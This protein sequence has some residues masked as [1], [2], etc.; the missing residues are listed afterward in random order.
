MG[1]VLV[2]LVQIMNGMFCD[3]IIGVL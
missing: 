2:I 3:N 1:N